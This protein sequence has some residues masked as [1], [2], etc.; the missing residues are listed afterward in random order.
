MLSKCSFVWF[1]IYSILC[2]A[3]ANL[4]KEGHLR[5]EGRVGDD[6]SLEGHLR[7]RHQPVPAPKA[8][9]VSVSVSASVPRAEAAPAAPAVGAAPAPPQDP[10]DPAGWYGPESVSNVWTLCGPGKGFA[11]E[12]DCRTR[13][14]NASNF[15]RGTAEVKLASGASQHDQ[16]EADKNAQDEAARIA[17]DGRASYMGTKSNPCQTV[18]TEHMVMHSNDL[19]VHCGESRC[20]GQPFMCHK[21]IGS[22]TD[23]TK[24][25]NPARRC[26][27]SD[28][29]WMCNPALKDDSQSIRFFQQ[30]CCLTLPTPP[31]TLSPT[32]APTPPPTM[33]DT[34]AFLPHNLGD[35]NS[36][37]ECPHV[38]TYQQCICKDREF[39]AHREVGRIKTHHNETKLCADPEFSTAAFCSYAEDA[40]ERM[41]FEDYCCSPGNSGHPHIVVQ[42]IEKPPQRCCSCSASHRD[43]MTAAAAAAKAAAAA[44]AARTQAQLWATAAATAAAAAGGSLAAPPE[45]HCLCGRG[46]FLVGAPLGDEK[47]TYG[48]QRVCAAEEAKALCSRGERDYQRKYFESFCCF[49]GQSRS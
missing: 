4:R 18:S 38:S 12:E 32:Q 48:R 34:S 21:Q 41:Y 19:Q 2:S 39:Y 16:Q 6:A 42:P 11:T 27:D 1:S 9:S 31:P 29:V 37:C 17:T 45:K 20:G 10:G 3:S 5:K 49:R 43:A 44:V 22:W 30:E 26:G 23:S 15:L 24:Q 35:S 14:G 47:D 40:P 13:I 46:Y 8:V 28:E 25:G 33:E 36:C 7:R